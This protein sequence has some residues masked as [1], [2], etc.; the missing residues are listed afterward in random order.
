MVAHAHADRAGK[1]AQKDANTQ[2]LPGEEEW[3]GQCTQVHD[4]DPGHDRPV[5]AEVRQ[6]VDAFQVAVRLVLFGRHLSQ[7]G[8]FAVFVPEGTGGQAFAK[9]TMPK[10]F[11]EV[12]VLLQF[13]IAYFGSHAPRAPRDVVRL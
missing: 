10:T 12:I 8:H 13:G 2:G 5:V 3:S 6:I 11:V 9:R 4:D 1:P 7:H